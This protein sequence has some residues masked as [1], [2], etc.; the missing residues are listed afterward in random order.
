[1]DSRSKNFPKCHLTFIN[2]N[3]NITELELINQLDLNWCMLGVGA[4]RFK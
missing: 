2:F 4:I 3:Q 1:M